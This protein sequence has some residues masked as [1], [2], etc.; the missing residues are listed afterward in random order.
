MGKKERRSFVVCPCC[1]ICTPPCRRGA[2]G[3]FVIPAKAGIALPDAAR[4]L[5]L[6]FHILSLTC[7]HA[8]K[9]NPD[10]FVCFAGNSF[11]GSRNRVC[12]FRGKVICSPP[13][14]RFYGF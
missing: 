3:I 7:R 13:D 12:F 5:F 10:S 8:C 6:P 9:R 11:G 14:N 2:D 1:R 4:D